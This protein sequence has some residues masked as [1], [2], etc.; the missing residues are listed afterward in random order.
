[1][2]KVQI[3]LTIEDFEE[4]VECPRNSFWVIHPPFCLFST[5]NQHIRQSRPQGLLAFNTSTFPIMHL[6]CSPPHSL[7][8][9]VC[10]SIVFSFSWDGCN[11]QEKWKTKVMQ[12]FLGGVGGGGRIRCVMGNVEVAYYHWAVPRAT[13]AIIGDLSMYTTQTLSFFSDENLGPACVLTV[14]II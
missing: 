7:P 13:H 11:T 6:I 4:G 2:I 1:M 14:E 9:K 10:I 3:I 5:E 12:I 8:K